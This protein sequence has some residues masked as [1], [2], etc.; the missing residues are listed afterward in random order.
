MLASSEVGTE[1]G[2]KLKRKRKEHFEY[3]TL[4]D[5]VTKEDEVQKSGSNLNTV[6]EDVAV[7]DKETQNQDNHKKRENKRKCKDKEGML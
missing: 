3:K 2:A 5:D 6:T 7:E 1:D 4:E